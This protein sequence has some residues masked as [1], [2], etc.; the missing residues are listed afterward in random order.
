MKRFLLLVVLSAAAAA[1]IWYAMRTGGLRTSSANVTALLP[2]ET[3]AFVHVPDVNGTRA[4]WH[5][6][7]LYKLWRE[8]ALQDFLQKP[9]SKTPKTDAVRQKMQQVESLQM[10]DAFLAI[11]S[12]ENNQLKMVGGFRFK[13]SAEEAEK[14]I[15]QWRARVH[16]SAP[17]A[18]QE[19]L[20][21][22]QH[23]I[24]VVTHDNVTVATAYDGDWF[25]A[26]NEVP[27]LKAL[28]DRADGR[29][30][31]AA[32][33]LAADEN[34]IAAFKHMPA[35]YA[36]FVYGRLDRYLARLAE[37]LPQDAGQS[38]QLSMLRQIRSIAG[39][40]GFDNGKI[41]DVL[42]LGMP[43]MKDTGDLSRSSL[44]LTTPESFLY[45][46]SFL[47]LPNQMP[48]AQKAATSG[49]PPAMQGLLK[50]FTDKGITLDYWKSAFGS[51]LG[52]IGDWPQNARLPALFASLA[53]KD[54]AK[55]KEIMATIAASTAGESGWTTSEKEGVQYYSQPP[56]NPMVPLAPT[57][58]LS[59]QL[60]VAGL[61]T[62]SVEAA[63]KRGDSSSSGLATSQTF[64]GA[65]RLVPPPKFSFAYIDSALFYTRLDAA[66]RPMLIMA[67]AFMPKV[68]DTVDLGKLPAADV[69]TKHLSPIVMSQT[70]QGDGYMT[71]SIG[72]V[73]LYQAA[74]GI[75]VATGLG[76]SL[77]QHQMSGAGL[78]APGTAAGTPVL[79]DET[80][81][82]SPE[83][84]PE[85]EP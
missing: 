36:A 47:N 50:A 63:I 21:Y 31:D 68:A 14:V 30:K 85:P 77:Y 64:K 11:L 43:K 15:G 66:V 84:N 60:L 67:A 51:E 4:K 44:A 49:F 79:P 58:G 16:R 56:A 19:K 80:P 2:K 33:A 26:A 61:D 7:D 27:A 39:A 38:E 3:T 46:A 12:W 6:T 55:A 8:P 75:V 70:Y 24:D 41:R 74:V 81:S 76:A 20:T 69:I 5:E 13:G 34:F 42:F 54:A 65:E 62:A 32:S 72:P 59:N 35:S 40:T 17:E 22:E 83:E 1:G 71:E 10:K 57:I 53:V 28:L 48:D 82:P 78:N 18:K 23:S 25:F 37:K 52:V 45:F 73:S 29:T 9:L